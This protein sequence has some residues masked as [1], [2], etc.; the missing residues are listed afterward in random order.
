M[1]VFAKQRDEVSNSQAAG[2]RGIAGQKEITLVV[3]FKGLFFFF[4]WNKCL[5][6]HVPDVG[7]EHS[8]RAG[9]LAEFDLQRGLT[10]EL[11]GLDFETVTG[12]KRKKR[13][14]DASLNLSVEHFAPE[15]VAGSILHS[16]LRFPVP[17]HL[18]SFAQVKRQVK[19]TKDP[20]AGSNVKQ[21]SG[22]TISMRQVLVYSKRKVNFRV[23][24]HKEEVLA[25]NL[26]HSPWEPRLEGARKN[27]VFLTVGAAPHAKMEIEEADAHSIRE[28][29]TG[30]RLIN[31]LD[32]RQIRPIPVDPICKPE[33]GFQD[34]VKLTPGFEENT[35]D[36]RIYDELFQQTHRLVA[37]S[38]GSDFTIRAGEVRTCSGCIVQNF[39]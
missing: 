33:Q 30:V 10:Y 22:K 24:Q 13:S 25:L 19:G 27:L 11:N 18:F 17:D 7:S 2:T 31:G 28:F 9:T 36:E 37:R 34:L 20:F 15:P 3:I 6:A 8:Y 38:I 26:R 16:I 23:D 39:D 32:V 14:F 1:G 5:E 12:A 4:E 35:L 21:L 29:N